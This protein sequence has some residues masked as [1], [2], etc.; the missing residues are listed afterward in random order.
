[1]TAFARP[2][3]TYIDAPTGATIDAS[4]P[5][6]TITTNNSINVNPVF[7]LTIIVPRIISFMSKLSFFIKKYYSFKIEV[8]IS[9]L[10]T[11]TVYD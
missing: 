7:L 10:V 5:I 1:M 3:I 11:I 4:K 2:V 9:N 8:L 6:I